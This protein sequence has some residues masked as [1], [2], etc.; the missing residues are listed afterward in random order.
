MKA[1]GE[2]QWFGWVQKHAKQNGMKIEKHL[3]YYHPDGL[4]L[5]LVTVFDEPKRSLTFDGECLFAPQ[6]EALIAN[7]VEALAYR[8]RKP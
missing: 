1:P 8:T 4:L 6:P 2:Q 3:A 7:E 5:E